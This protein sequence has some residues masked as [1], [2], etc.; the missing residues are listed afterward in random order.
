M[1][2]IHLL[3]FLHFLIFFKI[4][5]SFVLC[6]ETVEALQICRFGEYDKG[7]PP[8]EP[9]NP[10]RI[11]N[12]VTIFSMAEFDDSQNTVSLDI[13]LA[14]VWNDTRITLKSNDL[15]K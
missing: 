9:G 12:S 8:W 1:G 5:Q 3:V 7:Q 10:L 6:N 15:N 13:L 11:L 14:I 4:T 2:A